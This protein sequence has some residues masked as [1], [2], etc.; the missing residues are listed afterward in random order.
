M[1]IAVAGTILVDKINEIE[2]YPKVGELTEIHSVKYAI[3][4]CV[5]N[6]AADLKK[7][8]AA[9]EVKA[10]GCVGDDYFGKF[11]LNEL[12][13]RKIDISS[14]RI[15]KE[16]VT[17]FTE[18]MSI[19]GGQRTFFSYSGANDFFCERD[20]ELNAANIELLH[21]GY[22]LLLRCIDS[23]DGVRILKEAKR[24][25]IKTSIDLVSNHSEKYINVLSCLPFTDNLIINEIEAANLLRAEIP[26][27]VHQ[28]KKIAEELL[29]E[30]VCERVII[31]CAEYS[32]CV[33]S[34]GCTVLPSYSLPNLY[35]KGTTG[36]GDAFCAGCLLGIYNKKSDMEILNMATAAAT[37]SLREADS[38]NGLSDIND[39]L[40]YCC[41]F[42]R[43]KIC[44]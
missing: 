39:A 17:G 11:V 7:L 14:V 36:A 19:N 35:I 28:T 24:R 38:V 29:H 6:V 20:I 22:F 37:L 10:I 41:R 8:S 18:V 30:G 26:K 23:G 21:L 12:S 9:T 43:R 34:D 3:G 16:K 42:E 1:S 27:S 31:H 40:E 4:G 32:I 25:G 5:P 13:S 44:W 33:S 15:L 2:V